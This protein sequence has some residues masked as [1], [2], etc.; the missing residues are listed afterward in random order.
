[1]YRYHAIADFK[2]ADLSVTVKGLVWGKGYKWETFIPSVNPISYA[3]MG[4]LPQFQRTE[5]QIYETINILLKAHYDISYLP[6]MYR[7][8]I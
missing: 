5:V 6:Q 1:M 3:M 7:M 4:L 2:G 8:N